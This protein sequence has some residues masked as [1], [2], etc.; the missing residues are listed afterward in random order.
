[1]IPKIQV[2]QIKE[3]KQ[4]NIPIWKFESSE[5]FSIF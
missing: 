2:V 3:F 1:M 5:C 4:L